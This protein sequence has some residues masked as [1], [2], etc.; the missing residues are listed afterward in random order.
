MSDSSNAEK[1]II[2]DED[3]K[4]RAQ[5]EKEELAKKQREAEAAKPQD[6]GQAAAGAE[7]ADQGG[8]AGDMKWPQPSLPLLVTTLATQAMVALGLVPHPTSGK[9]QP[10]LAQAKHY[11]G[12]VELLLEKT[13]GNRSK[14]ETEM[15][16]EVLHQLRMGFVAINKA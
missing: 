2:I 3:W 6:E 16:E 15:L 5:E 9:P 12:T 13:E 8:S 10:D 1:K 4:T 7:G 11:I 14:E